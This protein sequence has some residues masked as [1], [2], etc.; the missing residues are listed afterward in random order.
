MTVRGELSDGSSELA[1]LANT[2]LQPGFVGVEVP[3]WV[4]RGSARV[5]ARVALFARN[6]VDTE[7]VAA[8]TA[9]LRAE[10]PTSSWPS[11]RRP[12]TSPGMERAHG[13]SRPG[14]LALGA[15][16]D[17]ELTE[18][19]ARDIGGDLASSASPSTTP[20]TPTS[21]PTRTTRSSAPARSAPTRLLVARH[22]AAWVPASSRPGSPPAPST[23]PGTATPAS[24]PTTTCPVI[25]PA[26]PAR[27][28]PSW[29]PFRAAVAAGVQAV[30]TGHL[31]SPP[32]TR[33]LPATLSRRILGGLLRDELGFPA[34]WS[35]TAWRCAPS[36]TGTAS[37]AATVRAL[38]AGADAICV[39]G[40]RA[41]EGAAACC[42]TP[43]S[44]PCT[45]ASCPSSVSPR[46]P[47]G[48]VSSPPGPGVA[49]R[50]APAHPGR[51]RAAAE[52]AWRS[53]P[54]GRARHA[55]PGT[56]VGLPLYPRPRT[57]RVRPADATSPSAP[58]DPVGRRRDR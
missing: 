46:P 21:T 57:C 35:P 49:A 53:R 13:S 52:S 33:D 58:G 47:T 10:G 30:M 41:D 4:R 8:L 55:A 40:E 42:A 27:R 6:V 22:T 43:S 5:S 38:A 28:R 26:G 36:P 39:G 31:R 48:S 14:N 11:T 17:P 20:P 32:S 18:G 3:D 19:V 1:G 9:T 54:P 56:T 15:V 23:S 25:R 7:Q 12:A 34:W 50:T 45:P 24:T 16:D 37:P 2:V 29:S 44:P 51:A